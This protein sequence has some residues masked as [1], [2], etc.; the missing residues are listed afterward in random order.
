MKKQKPK[1]MPGAAR[2]T[3]PAKK[4]KPDVWTPEE[5]ERAWLF[6]RARRY[7]RFLG[8]LYA[9][10]GAMHMEGQVETTALDDTAEEVTHALN[11]TLDEFSK[12]YLKD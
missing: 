4:T 1:S 11:R 6:Q 12:S 7:A 10:K 5:R 8:D 9:T 2:T 3:R